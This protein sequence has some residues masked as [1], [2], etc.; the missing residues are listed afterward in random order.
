[1]NHLINFLIYYYYYYIAIDCDYLEPGTKIC[2]EYDND[3]PIVLSKTYKIKSRDTCEKIARYLKTTPQILERV[4]P[5]NYFT[6]FFFFFLFL[7]II[8]NIIDNS[9]F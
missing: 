3:A 4:N 1:M 8:K 7:Y 5:S 2:V 9:V 6:L